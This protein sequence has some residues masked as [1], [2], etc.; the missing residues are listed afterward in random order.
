MARETKTKKAGG[1]KLETILAPS[2][3][4]A[5]KAKCEKRGLPM[6]QRLRDLVQR[7]VK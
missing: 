5:F 3:H 1:K 6:S 2:L 7:D 4:K